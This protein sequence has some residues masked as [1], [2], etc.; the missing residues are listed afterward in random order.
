M[1]DIK[2]EHFLSLFGKM[3]PVEHQNAEQKLIG[4]AIGKYT[5]GREWAIE[6]E[7]AEAIQMDDEIVQGGGYWKYHLYLLQEGAPKPIAVQCPRRIVNRPLHY[8]SE[9]HGLIDRTDAEKMLAEAGE[10]AYLVRASKRSADAYTLCIFFDGLVRNYKLYYDGSHYVGEKRFDTL[11]YLVADGL[12]SMYMDKHASDYIRKMADEA[13]YEQSPYSQYNR[14]A[15]ELQAPKAKTPQARCHNFV[16]FTFKIPQYCDYCRNFLWGVVQQGLRCADCGFAAHKKCSEQARHD[17][18]PEAKYVKRM[19]AVD[20][21]TLCMAHSVNVPPVVVKCI[22]EVERRGLTVEGIYRVSG[23]HDQME[24]LR[25]QF[26]LSMNVD[27]ENVEDIHTVAGV[28]KMYLRLLPQQLVPYSTFRSL[29]H[30]FGVT[31]NP[32]ERLRGCRKVLEELN[33]CNAHTLQRLLAHLN[34]ISQHCTENKMSAE[35]LATIFSPTIFCTGASPALPQHQHVLLHFL[36]ENCQ[37]VV[38]HITPD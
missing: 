37:R 27:L 28:L 1:S 26:D 2:F 13:I 20:L 10:G 25:R 31:R 24:R 3:F 4:R 32:R 33:E 14:S 21:T 35:N 36:I 22:A 34:V 5:V 38:P 29:L 16:S 18:R 8:G 30:S 11:D 23:S 19:F 7:Q 9:F 15:A 12:I 17:C 6:S